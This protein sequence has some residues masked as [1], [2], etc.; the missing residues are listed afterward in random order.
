MSWPATVRYDTE[1]APDG[2]ALVQDLMNTISVGRFRTTDLLADLGDARAWLDQAL[3]QWS[4]TTGAPLP[5]IQLEPRDREELCSFR[6]DLRR[7]ARQDREGSLPPLHTAA[8]STQLGGNGQVHLEPRGTGW[9]RVAAMVL[10]EIFQGQQA[11]M[12]QRLKLCRHDRC[13]TVFFDRS[14]N[15]NGV[16]CNVKACGNAVNVRAYQ[17]KRR[18][19][20]AS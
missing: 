20:R 5:G 7:A 16:W 6:D 13:G 8:V 18:V 3:A 14:R 9:R 19:Q 11:G 17:A 4:Q 2:L 12:W 10:I 1:P 15:R